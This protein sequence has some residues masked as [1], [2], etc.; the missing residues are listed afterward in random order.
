FA[1]FQ[2]AFERPELAQDPKHR[3]A[4]WGY[5]KSAG[6]STLP[7]SRMAQMYPA[8]SES[9]LGGL[10]GNPEFRLGTDFEKLMRRYKKAWTEKTIYPFVMPL[11]TDMSQAMLEARSSEPRRQPGV[12]AVEQ[13]A[14]MEEEARKRKH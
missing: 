2:E 9:V 11:E 14:L 12:S 6:I 1:L 3:D 10:V 13:L 4:L 5:L 7:F 8:N